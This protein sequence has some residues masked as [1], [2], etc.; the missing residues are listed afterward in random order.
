VGTGIGAAATSS[1]PDQVVATPGGVSSTTSQPKAKQRAAKTA[2]P[3]VKARR[4]TP[5]QWVQVVKNTD[6]Y[7]GERF[8]VY[9]QVTQLDAATGDNSFMADT[10]NRDTTDYGYFDGENTMLSGD[11]DLFDDLVEADVFRATVTVTG[12]YRYDTRAG[13]NTTVPELHVDSL[14]VTGHNS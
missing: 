14:A 11:S 4:A 13:G 6:V 1:N 5:R 9:G 3:A 8:I 12:S 7:A 10:A 2:Q